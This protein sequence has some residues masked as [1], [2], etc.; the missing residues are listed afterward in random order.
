MHTG[1]IERALRLLRTI[2]GGYVNDSRDNGGATNHGV[3]I[4]S[5]RRMDAADKLPKYL[6][7]AFDVD[8]DGDIDEK[9]VPGWTWETACWFYLKEYWDPIRLSEM[10]FPVALGLFDSAVNEGPGTAVRHFQAARGLTV[11]G[12][13]G[14]KTIA[15]AQQVV[16]C[17]NTLEAF[18]VEF[19]GY[20]LDRYR[21]LDDA[22]V[23]FRGWA[24]RTVLVALAALK[25][26]AA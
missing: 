23:F 24:N 4:R 11:D 14:P 12:I 17:G 5:V 13:V 3:S 8:D 7:D 2:E 19:A 20:R 10:P 25:E 9:D 26:Y 1:S 22:P 6:K 21:K 18:L 16:S 15:A